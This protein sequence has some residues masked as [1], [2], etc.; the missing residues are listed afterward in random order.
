[1]PRRCFV[2][3]GEAEALPYYPRRKK[4]LIDE[5]KL[6]YFKADWT[7]GIGAKTLR[8]Q[9]HRDLRKNLSRVLVSLSCTYVPK[10]KNNLEGNS[11]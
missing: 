6:S 11:K 1:M 9:S 8:P 10:K 4:C 7:I 3:H 5:A 2:R